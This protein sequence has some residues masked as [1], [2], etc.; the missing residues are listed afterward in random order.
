MIDPN[1]AVLTW[2]QSSTDLVALVGTNIY[3][4]VLPEGFSAD[5][6]PAPNAAT[7]A[8]VVRKRGGTSQSEVITVLDPSF[9]IEC[10]AL[11]APDATQIY[12]VIRDLMHGATS[13]DLGV[14]GFVIL[15]QEEV[16]GQDFTDPETHWSMVFAYYHVKLRSSVAPPSPPNFTEAYGTP[17][18]LGNN[19]DLYLNL[20]NGDLYE[21]I[22]G[23]WVLVGNVPQG[24][25]TEMPSLIYH[26]VAA[27][28]T[29]AAAIKSA[30]GVVTGWKIYNDTEYP[31]YVKL[32]DQAGAP[33]PGV[34]VPKQTIGVDAGLGEV[35]NSAGFT[36]SSGIAI[37]ITKGID[38]D[39]STAV[40]AG[41]CVVDLFYQ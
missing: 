3:S 15:A 11:E 1:L 33:D 19:G 9:A 30:A 20:L 12:G 29:N 2:L 22:L 25:S 18:A 26:K 31:I 4:P 23:A 28:G 21:Q 17:G 13:I 5:A 35:S 38:D 36:Y 14:A 24:G 37:A 10:W 41:D 32:Y 7:R 40:A 27:S 8:V 34:D 39:D 16:P 6:A